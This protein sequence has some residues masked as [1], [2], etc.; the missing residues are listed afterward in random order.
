MADQLSPR[1]RAS[2]LDELPVTRDG[3]VDRVQ[4]MVG[5]DPI[6][7]GDPLVPDA[8]HGF[9]TEPHMVYCVNPPAP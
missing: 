1:E 3:A 6:E 7:G 4:Q 8:C 5:L 9:Y 2:V